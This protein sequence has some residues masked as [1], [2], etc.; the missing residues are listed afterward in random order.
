M[1]RVNEVI[2]INKTGTKDNNVS[3]TK[4]LMVSFEPVPF[5]SKLFSV[6]LTSLVSKA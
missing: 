1:I 3:N 5:D 2:M 4:V 6:V